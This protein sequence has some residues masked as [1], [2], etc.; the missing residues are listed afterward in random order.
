[1]FVRYFHKLCAATAVS[2]LAGCH[3]YRSMSFQLCCYLPFSFSNVQ[4]IFLYHE[5]QHMWMKAVC[6]KEIDFSVF[7]ELSSSIRSYYQLVAASF[8]DSLDCF[9]YPIGPILATTQLG[10]IH[11]WYGKLHLL[12]SDFHVELYQ[13][14]WQFHLYIIYFCIYFR[15]YLLYQ[16]SIKSL[17]CL[18][19]TPQPHISL[20]L[21]L[22]VLIFQCPCLTN[23]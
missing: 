13:P 3:K 11:S 6:R 8:G 21:A 7:N 19:I 10:A 9:G 1:M 15:K 12:M 16:F 17:K 22:L 14:V 5:H 20:C 4:T 23:S 2:Y 18:I